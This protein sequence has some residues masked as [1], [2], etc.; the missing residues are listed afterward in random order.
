MAFPPSDMQRLELIETSLVHTTLIRDKGLFCI[1]G[2]VDLYTVTWAQGHGGMNTQ[3]MSEL[4]E[5]L[6]FLSEVTQFCIPTEQTI[7]SQ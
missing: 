5:L 4:E 7:T 2:R 3:S 1:T 6:T